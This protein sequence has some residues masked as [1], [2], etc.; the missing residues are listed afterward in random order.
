MTFHCISLYYCIIFVKFIKKA[1]MYVQIYVYS[2]YTY[3]EIDMYI[4]LC[5]IEIGI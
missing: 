3:R 1:Y 2:M 5:Y 4:I